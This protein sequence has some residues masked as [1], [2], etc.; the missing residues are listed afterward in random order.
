MHFLWKIY[1]K[2]KNI[3]N[4]IYKADFEN[5]IREKLNY[6]NNNFIHIKSNYLINVG[7]FKEFYV[8]N[9]VNNVDNVLEISEMHKLLTK[10]L[11]DNNKPN[12]DFSEENMKD[13][14]E[15]FYD[16]V[17]IEND[18]F[19]IGTSCILWN[20][21][22]DILEAI[23]NKFQKPI[24]KDVSMYDAYVMYCKYSNNNGKLLTVSKSY[25]YKYIDRII[26]EQYIQN[27]KILISYWDNFT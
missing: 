6:T 25:F 14:L 3:P 17:E 8:T 7:Y 21:K 9:I 2:Q 19:M 11:N 12:M 4:I 23:D 27:N 22:Q 13:M 24:N 5:I 1:I 10:W 18:K 15:Y 20:K 26:P 16:D